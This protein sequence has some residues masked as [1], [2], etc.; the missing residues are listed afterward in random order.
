MGWLCYVTI[1]TIL[2]FWGPFVSHEWLKLELLKFVHRETRL[3]QVLSKRIIYQPEKGV[4]VFCMRNCELEKFAKARSTMPSTV[5][6]LLAPTTV[7]DSN[8][9]YYRSVL[10]ACGR[11]R[12][13]RP[14]LH[15]FDL[16]SICC[17]L[18]CI[19]RRQQIDQVECE[20]HRARMC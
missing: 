5:D 8:A 15:R 6:L 7:D 9:V 20:P 13:S 11:R 3:Y 12:S 18:V 19:M 4:V 1:L 17:K 16:L 14:K 10:T 2:N